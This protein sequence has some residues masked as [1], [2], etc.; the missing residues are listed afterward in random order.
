MLHVLDRRRAKAPDHRPRC[1]A[2]RLDDDH[3]VVRLEA[4]GM[5]R[6]DLHIDIDRDR[7]SV[8]GERRFDRETR[9]GDHHLV[10]CAYGSFRRDLV[11]PQ[12]VDAEQAMASSQDGVPRIETPRLE[13]EGGRRIE[14][15]G[16]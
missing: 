1:R 8:W 10:Q 16:G 9:D 5:R 6:D 13:R 14:V 2:F 12:P 15:R 3:G 4:P 11:L 7:L